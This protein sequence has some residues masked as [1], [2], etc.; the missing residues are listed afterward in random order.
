[1][2]GVGEVDREGM[3]DDKPVPR[4][5]TEES[6][7]EEEE[8]TDFDVTETEEE[9]ENNWDGRREEEEETPRIGPEEDGRTDFP[10]KDEKEEEK[11]EKAE[12]TL[13]P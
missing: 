8:E 11:E 9:E 12:E 1:M 5:L 3:D 6:R 2:T 7:P 13:I 10:E 4:L